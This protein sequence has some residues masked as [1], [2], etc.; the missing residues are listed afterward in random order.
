LTAP[1]QSPE[2]HRQAVGSIIDMVS[3]YVTDLTPIGPDELAAWLAALPVPTGWQIGRADNSP[4]QPTRTIVHCRDSL[5]GWDACETINVFRFTGVPPHDIIRFN[6]D[7]TLRA[8]GAHH[9]TI[10][11]VQTPAGA[12][13]TAIRS[14]GYLTLTKQQ[15][16][17][18]QHSTYIAGDD[19][20]GL[21]VEHGIFAVPDRQA[22]LRDDI[23]ELSN[24]VRDTFVATMAAVPE[25]HVHTP[26]SPGTGDL[27]PSEGAKMAIFRIGFFAGY[28]DGYDAVLVGADRDGMRMLQSAARSA[29]DN[30]SASFEFDT[31]KHHILRQGGAADIELGP[32]NVVWRFDDAALA[33]MLDLIEPLVDIIKPAHNYLDLNSPAE[34]LI[35]SVDELTHGGPFAEFPHGEPVPPSADSKQ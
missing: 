14:S 27:P 21:L 33:E 16:I 17:W 24:A 29:R 6:A 30:G 22:G 10:H 26:S 15:S 12:T 4:V 25:Q 32:Q 9:I 11:P 7:R 5:A 18:T 13:M 2:S 31:I 23:T 34:T 28:D 35:L 8:C 1:N 19:T 3:R 20:Q